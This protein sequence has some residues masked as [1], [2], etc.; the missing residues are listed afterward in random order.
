MVVTGASLGRIT[1]SGTLSRDTGPRRAQCPMPAASRRANLW[2][3]EEKKGVTSERVTG[4][5]FP[6]KGSLRFRGTV[7]RTSFH[8]D[9]AAEPGMGRCSPPW[10]R[11][12]Q[13]IFSAYQLPLPAPSSVISDAGEQ[14]PG[15]WTSHRPSAHHGP[16][17]GLAITV[18]WELGGCVPHGG[19]PATFII[20]PS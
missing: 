20:T 1:I 2:W 4:T 12:L 11:C 5:S 13:C 9:S 10:S 15:G 14:L 7:A 3:G 16:S 18:G 6:F 8:Q 17:A 19:I